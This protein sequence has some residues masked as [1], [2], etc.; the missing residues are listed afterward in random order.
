MR[1]PP[2]TACLVAALACGVGCY[3]VP[4]RAG[5]DLATVGDDG[6]PPDVSSDLPQAP[7]LSTP[8]DAAA[9]RDGSSDHDA[10]VAPDSAG[11]LGSPE[12]GATD[13]GVPLDVC[14][15]TPELCN[16][17]DDDCDGQVDED[18]EP[19]VADQ[20]A[21]VC[22]NALKECRGGQGWR[23]PN[24]AQLPGYENRRERSCDDGRDNDCDGATDAAD[25][26]CEG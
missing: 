5:L 26:D 15:P 18:L 17:L 12:V 25:E 23:E 4:E 1:A 3:H 16:G 6:A 19:P 7:D 24:Y 20:N 9:R 10:R 11:D 8:A 14:A 2:R 13:L 22:A 21:G